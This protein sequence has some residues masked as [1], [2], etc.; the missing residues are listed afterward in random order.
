VSDLFE[1]LVR[2]WLRR[3]FRRGV[4]GGERV[5]IWIGAGALGL[6]LATRLFASE[7]RPKRLRRRLDPGQTI[8]VR[9]LLSGE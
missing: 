9:H 7:G 3:G 1:E 6:R 2:V 5:W 4:V 8:V